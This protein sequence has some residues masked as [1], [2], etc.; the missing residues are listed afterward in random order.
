MS[1]ERAYFRLCSSC[2]KELP[3]GGPYYACSVSTCNRKRTA[4]SFC[5][6]GC[7]EA[8]VPLVRHRDAWAEEQR[9]PSRADWLRSQEEEE[10]KEQARQDRE[11]RAQQPG[12]R[13]VAIGTG[14][15]G[16][17]SL[18]D[19]DLPRDT[20]IVISKL[21]TYIRARSGMNT[22]DG[23]TDVLSD[24]VREL[25]DAAIRRAAEEGRKT[26]LERDF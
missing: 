15:S 4:L 26:V 18:N 14:G 25:C 16:A 2:K 22:S 5:S 6:V 9:A 8:H 20:L 23:C 21:K 13:V 3:F 1:E 12:R 17:L 7:W 11:A 10:L 24:I 19:R